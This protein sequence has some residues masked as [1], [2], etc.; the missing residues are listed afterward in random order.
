MNTQSSTESQQRPR[1][2]G[3]VVTVGLSVLT[4]LAAPFVAT[5]LFRLGLADVA[6]LLICLAVTAALAAVPH[7]GRWLA[8]G[9]LAGSV[10]WALALGMLLRS[11][12]QGMETFN[13]A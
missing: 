5:A 7:R 9:W 10:L 2:R 12:G 11:L 8:L 13:A 1:G 3:P 6:V 4:A